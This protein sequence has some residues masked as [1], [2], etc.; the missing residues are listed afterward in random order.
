M[1][2]EMFERLI[3]AIDSTDWISNVIGIFSI[4]IPICYA[5]SISKKDT[6]ELDE[7]QKKLEEIQGEIRDNIKLLSEYQVKIGL[8]EKRR[9]SY[10]FFKDL[11]DNW[12]FYYEHLQKNPNS[13][14][15]NYFCKEYFILNQIE[16][17][18]RK[19]EAPQIDKLVE[20][21]T[22]KYNIH[23]REFENLKLYYSLSEAD[24]TLVEKI[25]SHFEVI[26]RELLKF[27]QGIKNNSPTIRVDFESNGELYNIFK[28]NDEKGESTQYATLLKYIETELLINYK[29]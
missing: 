8:Y 28:I 18:V 27:L 3:N 7:R 5:I 21:L 20:Y 6:K 1:T 25:K 22:E 10:Y 16:I 17:N 2:P 9:H 13:V 23:D 12:T 14:P 4:F 19:L 29:K 24:I 15:L 11:G 26:Y